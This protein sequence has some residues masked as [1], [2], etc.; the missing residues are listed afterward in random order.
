MKLAQFTPL[1]SNE[2][3]LGVLIDDRV[4]AVSALALAASSPDKQIPAWLL[5]APDMLDVI[6]RGD[7][8]LAGIIALTRRASSAPFE[9]DDRFA[10]PVDSVSF[11]PPVYPSK[12]IAIGRNYVDHAIE[13]GSE[14]PTAPLIFNK[15]PNSLSAHNA[16][17]VLHK[18][19]T[20]IDY[21]AELAV[22]IGRRATRVSESEALGYVFGY[23]LI[24]DVSARDL[25]FGDGQWVRGKSLD[26]FAPL[27]PFITTRDEIPDVQALN[28]EG[29][30]NGEVMQSS[31]TRKMIFGVAYLVSYISQGIT[32]EPGDVIATGTPDGVGIFRK[33]PV[34]LK[35]GD[36]YEVTIEGLGT[37]RNPVVASQ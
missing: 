14:P 1:G 37:L 35:A 3:S 19:S 5:E 17:I 9:I 34:L 22:V 13:G 2:Q 24:N 31:N 21:E 12:I 30:L 23:T 36:V 10:V 25:Q 16:P 33:P 8:G 7:R 32:L 28:I 6:E 20:Q 26:G 27:G 4:V 15:L 29:R 11:L 18:I